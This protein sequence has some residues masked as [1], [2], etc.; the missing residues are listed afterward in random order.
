M[1]KSANIQSLKQISH[2]YEH[3]SHWDCLQAKWAS[4]QYVPTPANT[5]EGNLFVIMI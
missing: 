3:I 5:I 4:H 1:M 2:D